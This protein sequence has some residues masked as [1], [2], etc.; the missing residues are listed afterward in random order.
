MIKKLLFGLFATS[1]ATTAAADDKWSVGTIEDNGRPI[2][3]RAISNIPENIDPSLYRNMIAITWKFK[4]ESG[5][6]S[7]EEKERMN[8]LEDSISSLVES[9][10]QAI[11]TIVV[12][13]NEVAEW[14]FY[15]KSQEDFM[16]LLNQA[17]AGKEVFP[18]EV[19]LQKDPEWAAYNKFRARG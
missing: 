2:I 5:M 13:G 9:K 8:D 12:T 7:S 1:I 6:P 15:A 3:I 14:Q 18:I 4:S 17:L 19:S 11:L 16:G 10:S